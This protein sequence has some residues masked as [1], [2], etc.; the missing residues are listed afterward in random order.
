[1]TL[2]SIPDTIEAL[3]VILLKFEQALDPDFD[4]A[5][6]TELK[7]IILDRIAELEAE[8]AIKQRCARPSASQLEALEV[9]ARDAPPHTLHRERGSAVD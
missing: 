3:R 1:M 9:A 6:L 5:A 2:R 4:Q 8:R 7:R